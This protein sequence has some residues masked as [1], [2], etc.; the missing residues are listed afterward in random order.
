MSAVVRFAMIWCLLALGVQLS[1]AQRSAGLTGEAADA[2]GAVLSNA[3]VTVTQQLTGVQWS[4]VTNAAGVYQFVELEPGP[5]RLDASLAG[6]KTFETQVVLD[7]AHI[8]TV[9]I[10]LTVGSKNETVEVSAQAAALETQSATV[11]SEI[12]QQL[13]S[14]LPVLSRSAYD[15]LPATMG[16]STPYKTSGDPAFG[17]G[18]PG[19]TAYYVDGANALDTRVQT[20]N[21][22]SPASLEIVSE[23]KVVEN[24]FGAE[25]GQN[26][27]AVVLMTTKSG[28]NQFH[29]SVFD[30]NQQS[31]FAAENYFTPFK[32]PQLINDFGGE[33]GG[34]IRK[35]KLHFFYAYEGLRSHASSTVAGGGG[36]GATFQTLPTAM[37]RQ[38]D[39]SQTYN[40]AGVLT[41]IYDPRSSVVHPDGTITRTQISCN[42]VLNVICPN[43]L[44]PIALAVLAYEPLPNHAPADPSGTNNFFGVTN[45]LNRENQQTAKIDW[46]P[47]GKD[48]IS[49]RVLWATYLGQQY[50]P[51]PALAGFNSSSVKYATATLNPADPTE[52]VNPHYVGNVAVS[53]T[54]TITTSLVSDFHFGIAPNGNT[55]ESPSTGLNFPQKIGLTIPTLPDPKLP[56][57]LAN[58]HFPTFSAG[59]YTLP[60]ANVGAGQTVPRLNSWNFIETVSWLRGNHAFKAGVEYKYSTASRYIRTNSSGTYSF[61]PSTTASNPFDPTSGNALAS[62]LLDFPVSGSLTDDAT[63]DFHTNYYAWFVQDNW[64]VRPNVTVSL[65]LRHEIDTP[66]RETQNRINGF[67][68]TAINPVSGT[69]GVITFPTSAFPSSQF[70]GVP[71]NGFTNPEYSEF[72]PRIGVSYNPGGGKMVFRGGFGIFYNEFQQ[73]DIWSIP[74]QDR[75]DVN[76]TVS[77]STPDNGVTAPYFLSTG[78]PQPP[79][80]SPS[81][82][83][84][85][86]GAVA[87]VNGNFSPNKGVSYIPRNNR[88]GYQEDFTGSVQRS[89][90]NMVVELGYQ[91]NFG[92]RLAVCNGGY[93]CALALNVLTPAQLL[94]LGPTATQNNLPFPQFT[95]VTE[96][97]PSNYNSAYNAGFVKLSGH[98]GH[99]L[100]FLTHLTW[101]KTIDDYSALTGLDLYDVKRGLSYSDRAF[102]WVFAGTYNLPAGRG[103]RFLNSGPLSYVLG[104]WRLAP[105]IE[106]ES[107]QP[108]APS[109][110]NVPGAQYA[111]CVGNPNDGPKR[112]DDWFNQAAFTTP[113]PFTRGT[114]GQNVIIG[115]GWVGVDLSIQKEFPIFGDSKKLAFRMDNS[116]ILNH[117]NFGN[118]S[119][120]ICPPTAPCTT[121]LI[122]SAYSGRNIQFGL[123]FIF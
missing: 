80:F 113:A 87:P 25:Y 55:D 105:L 92:H 8:A 60:G 28:T 72:Q 50:G 35:N 69:P 30:F 18:I 102:R 59:P 90:R 51:W 106:I 63:Q 65:G 42:G 43:E 99:D 62:F 21:F 94:Q 89:V 40:S 32:T 36:G 54:R 45:N 10:K 88:S 61:S 98:F 97:N 27:G 57:G 39:F 74:S 7:T 46:D 56:N 22:T 1:W 120:T 17:G 29:G 100:T 117:P 20:G 44:S 83:V 96:M 14:D 76:T 6:F 12:G 114:C 122:T 110:G 33:V 119:S 107:G 104:G 49:G 93:G 82:L 31:A 16:Y 111:S 79:P 15:L 68:P 9:N 13:I 11:G 37:Q 77:V 116:N 34:P 75:P 121:D 52:S 4:T 108:L 24:N 91:G 95:S 112:L 47:T 78:L 26:G 38:G 85:G 3:T 70:T 19:S 118:P 81:Q 58:N 66:L 123:R 5:Y 109:L 115:P 67:D 23:V 84:P 64:K 53:W 103:E 71:T 101:S 2:S 86:F 48:K 41:P 73:L